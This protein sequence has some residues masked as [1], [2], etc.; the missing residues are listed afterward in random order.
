MAYFWHKLGFL[1]RGRNFSYK[2]IEFA[3]KSSIMYSDIIL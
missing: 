2:S 1:L 3:E